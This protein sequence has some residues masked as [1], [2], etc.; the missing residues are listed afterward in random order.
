M[1]LVWGAQ[2]GPEWGMM[3]KGWEQQG[4]G[5]AQWCWGDSV[6]GCSGACVG[7]LTSWH[8]RWHSP[9]PCS[10]SMPACRAPGQE[11]TQ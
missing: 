5:V 1:S 9:S 6:W 2:D 4:T 8:R 11:E 3:V 10:H 7:I